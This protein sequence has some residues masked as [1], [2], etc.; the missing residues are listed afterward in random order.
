M[1]M[2][3][4]RRWLRGVLLLLLMLMIMA[5]VAVLVRRAAAGGERDGDGHG[6]VVVRGEAVEGGA[7]ATRTTVDAA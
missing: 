6:R 7:A 2:L 4:R 1:A 5:T 3:L